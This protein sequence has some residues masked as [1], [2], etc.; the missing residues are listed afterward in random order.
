MPNGLG[1]QYQRLSRGQKGRDKTSLSCR[2]HYPGFS[3]IWFS[4]QKT[5]KNMCGIDADRAPV[6]AHRN[7]FAGASPSPLG[8]AKE[9]RA[10]GPNGKR[11]R[12][13][14]VVSSKS[15]G[16]SCAN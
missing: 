1:L 14:H 15:L 13:I 2:N 4:A 16:F 3:L 10:V 7:S 8:W 6:G 12:V 11:N 5:M 9:S